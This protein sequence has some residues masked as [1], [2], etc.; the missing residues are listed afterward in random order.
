MTIVRHFTTD[1]FPISMPGPPSA[2]MLVGT[3]P[4]GTYRLQQTPDG[5]EL[6]RSIEATGGTRDAGRPPSTLEMQEA[7]LRHYGARR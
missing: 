5:V 6:W 2:E 4:V 3:L 7:H 1:T